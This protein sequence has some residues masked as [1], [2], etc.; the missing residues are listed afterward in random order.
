MLSIWPLVTLGAVAVVMWFV[1]S[2]LQSSTRGQI[3]RS[4]VCP[5]TGEE[6]TALLQSDFFEPQRY[7][8]VLACSRFAGAGRPTCNRAC[9]RLEKE[10]IE[11]QDSVRLPLP[12]A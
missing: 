5:N 9:L 2:E 1:G 12:I 3:E 10:N 6:V 11:A 7:R 8:D 4:F